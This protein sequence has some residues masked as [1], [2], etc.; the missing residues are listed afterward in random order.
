MVST[1]P[2]VEKGYTSG[3]TNNWMGVPFDLDENP[4]LAWPN[5]VHVFDQMR[6]DP[7]VVSVLGAV[8]LPLRRTNWLVDPAGA[9][10]KVVQL[11]ADDLGLPISGKSPRAM[12]RTRDR[13]SWNEHLRLALLKIVFGH[14]VFE[15]TYRIVNGQ[16]RLRK[17]GWRP[18][19]TITAWDV[20]SDGGL[21]A[22]YQTPVLTGPDQGIP[23]S[24]LVVYSHE[25]EGGNWVGRSVLR[26]AYGPWW[27]KAQAM[28][29]QAVALDR[30]GLGVPVYEAA[31]T[32]LGLTG[33]DEIKAWSDA[34]VTA[35]LD[36]T[37]RLRGGE[38]AGMSIANGAKVSLMGV[39]GK[40]P[41]ANPTLR[42]YDEQIAGSVLANFLKLGGADT[43]GSYALGETFVN[44]FILSLQTLAQDICDTVTQHVI[45]DIVD[46]NFGESEP[47]PRLVCD[48][49]GSR[50]LPTAQA[51]QSLMQCGALTPDR[52]L[53]ERIRTSFS[54]PPVDE[55]TRLPVV[56]PAPTPI[57]QEVPA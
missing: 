49:I 2:L 25:R 23:V 13:F 24:Q 30:N 57:T 12:P 27:L 51:I 55:A 28:R 29:T 50:Q 7:Q 9:R 53:E 47:A 3:T 18:P 48:E 34:E 22:V 46:L 36:L 10:S 21:Q 11:V 8:T 33:E 20:A 37:T 35:G 38:N 52:T 17:L 44:F 26:A 4:E 14:S 54:L 56:T 19:K 31:P 6:R 45:E 32:P 39:T 43:K 40:V 5:S 1:A 15:Q 16:A 42:Y 41:D